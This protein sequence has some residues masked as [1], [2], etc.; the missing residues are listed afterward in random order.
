MKNSIDFI[1]IDNGDLGVINL[2][3]MIPI[4]QFSIIEYNISDEKNFKYAELLKNQLRFINS[5]SK[6]I[7]ERA[8]KLYI[9]VTEYDSFIKERCTNFRLLELK[10]LEYE[11]YIDINKEIAS[12]SV[13][14]NMEN[15]K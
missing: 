4:K 13:D 11:K 6:V 9:K 1:K 14:I 2:N 12:S 8:Y 10:C 3:N 5:N 7:K 15:E